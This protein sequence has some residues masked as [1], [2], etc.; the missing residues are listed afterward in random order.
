[1]SEVCFT[2]DDLDSRLSDLES[3][4]NKLEED[5]QALKVALE[6]ERMWLS[7]SAQDSLGVRVLE[8]LITQM[9]VSCLAARQTIYAYR[10]EMELSN[11][12]PEDLTDE[13]DNINA[14]IVK[15]GNFIRVVQIILI[16]VPGFIAR[17]S[18][19]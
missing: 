15:V 6:R 8:D 18:D 12:L 9:K 2:K 4:V 7:G 5:V 13:Y 16:D 17:C 3:P 19:R 10:L 11:W 1:L 14:Q